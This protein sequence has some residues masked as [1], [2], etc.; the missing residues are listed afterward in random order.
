MTCT[1]I[2]TC[3]LE[4]FFHKLSQETLIHVSCDVYVKVYVTIP[5]EFLCYWKHDSLVE[6]YFHVPLEFLCYVST[7]KPGKDLEIR[8]NYPFVSNNI[9]IIVYV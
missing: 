1:A 2:K 6:V 4:V 3:F 8:H 9:I 7:S 5:V